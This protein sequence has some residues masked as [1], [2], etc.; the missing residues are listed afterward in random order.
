[1]CGK[2]SN[3]WSALHLIVVAAGVGARFGA[4]MPKQYQI[5]CGRPL[6]MTTIERL[7]RIAPGA[8]MTLVV[9]REMEAFWLELCQRHGFVSPQLAYGGATRAESVSNAL[10]TVGPDCRYVAVHDGVR[11]LV[12]ADVLADALQAVET[13]ADG[14]IPAVPVTDSLREV[15]ADGGSEPVD[16]TRYRAVQ[17]PQVFR[18]DRLREAYSRELRPEF[19]DDASV[20]SAAGYADIRLTAGSPYNIK[21]THPRDLIILEALTRSG[22]PC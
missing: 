2:G 17:T 20:M 13:G 14:A 22:N 11:P 6:L 5:L 10:A 16:R 1:M 9:S 3:D 18:A 19:T 15:N 21:L 8:H 7:R 4:A 12:T